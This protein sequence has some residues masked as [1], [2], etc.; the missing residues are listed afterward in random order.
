MDAVDAVDE[1]NEVMCVLFL[2]G[3][4]RACASSWMRGS[5][6]NRKRY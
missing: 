4:T 1:M 3:Q 6:S 5:Q 2:C